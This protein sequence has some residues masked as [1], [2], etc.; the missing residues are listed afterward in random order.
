M[1]FTMVTALFL[2]AMIGSVVT[3]PW[4]SADARRTLGI[5]AFCGLPPVAAAAW[6]RFFMIEPG[7]NPSR[8][9]WIEGFFCIPILVS[10]LLLVAVVVQVSRARLFA[11]SIGLAS[12]CT[13]LAASF[14]GAMEVTGTWI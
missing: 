10:G 12:L 3:F 14:L 9:W 6:A 13:T 1:M 11:L 8:P 2:T 7:Y 5:L 4:R